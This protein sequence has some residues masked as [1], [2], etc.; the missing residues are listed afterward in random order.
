[1]FGMDIPEG[2]TKNCIILQQ[3]K[4]I[5]PAIGIYLNLNELL[6]WKETCTQ[7]HKD[8]DVE[9]ILAQTRCKK[10]LNNTKSYIPVLRHYAAQHR[11]IC[12]L[13]YKVDLVPDNFAQRI[14]KLKKMLIFLRSQPSCPQDLPQQF[15]ELIPRLLCEPSKQ[16]KTAT[17]FSVVQTNLLNPKSEDIPVIKKILSDYNQFPG[18]SGLLEALC[19]LGDSDMVEQYLAIDTRGIDYREENFSSCIPSKQRW[20]SVWSRVDHYRR[21]YTKGSALYYACIHKQHKLAS[22]LIAKGATKQNYED[23]DSCRNL[24]VGL[25]N[26]KR[27]EPIDSDVYTTA[28]LLLEYGFDPNDIPLHQKDITMLTFACKDGGSVAFARLMLS[29]GANINDVDNR[30]YTTLHRACLCCHLGYC[31]KIQT[32]TCC[33]QFKPCNHMEL[34]DLFLEHKADPNTTNE[35]DIT[36][37]VTAVNSGNLELVQKL[38]DKGADINAVNKDK[39]TYLMIALRDLKS[40]LCYPMVD[41]LL[42]NGADPNIADNKGRTARSIASSN[43]NAAVEEL[44]IRYGAVSPWRKYAITGATIVAAAAAAICYKIYLSLL[45]E[46]D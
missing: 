34:I 36:P 40:E 18:Q 41:L 44:L 17:Q 25:C 42:R 21:N 37:L 38:I 20:E 28:Q 14:N 15:E 27:Y 2:Q 46:S 6:N 43:N 5:I 26:H 9:N 7:F 33:C 8:V 30:G 12:Q 35:S 11:D 3:P 39:K 16:E 22:F 10:I 29:Y 19:Y 32:N 13:P 1:M 4:E 31:N 24:L 45:S 23:H